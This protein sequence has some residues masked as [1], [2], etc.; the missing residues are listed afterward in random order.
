VREP[1][2]R[3]NQNVVGAASE[4]AVAVAVAVAVAIAV[5]AA[6]ETATKAVA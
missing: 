6:M 5:H 1:R 4:T 2:S 3:H